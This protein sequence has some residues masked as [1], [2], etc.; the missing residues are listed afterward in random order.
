MTIYDF[1]VISTTGYPFFYITLEEEPPGIDLR[2]LFFHFHREDYNPASKPENT[3]E[4]NAGLISALYEF[5]KLLDQPIDF[6][7][8]KK[9]KLAEASESFK[10][11]NANDPEYDMD[12]AEIGTLITTRC[13]VY[14][15][16]E[17]I[18]KKINRIFEAYFRN[19]HPLGP[20]KSMASGEVEKIKEILENKQAHKLVSQHKDDLKK[21][22]EG[23]LE[24]MRQY[25]LLGIIICAFDMSP[26]SSYGLEDDQVEE[27]MRNLGEIP[28]VDTYN[29]KYR[30]SRFGE[31]RVWAFIVNSGCGVTVEGLFEHFYYFLISQP[32]SF[33]GEVPSKL[34]QMINNILD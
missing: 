8:F 27:I 17:N 34:Y 18:G 12:E 15:R 2:L 19:K 14:N 7:Q 3:F 32:G 13:D 25:G 28:E 21:S 29:W 30:Q 1:S 20:D 16:Q 5:A 22:C 26:L 4:L 33:L 6:L 9:T 24:E 10:L 23:F 11:D 31:T